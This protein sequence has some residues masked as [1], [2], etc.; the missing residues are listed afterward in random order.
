[1]PKG[2]VGR[3]RRAVTR[4]NRRTMAVAVSPLVAAGGLTLAAGAPAQAASGATWDRL[5]ACESGGNWSINTGNGYYGGLQFS[6][7]T[8][9]AYGGERYADNAHQAS[10]SEQIAIAEKTLAGQ[11]WG[12]WPACSRKLGLGASDKGGS[13]EAPPARE[14]RPEQRS[15]ADP[16]SAER[17]AP[18]SSRSQ[19]RSGERRDR[20]SAESSRSSGSYTVRAGDTLAR[21]ASAQGV[22]GGW[23]ALWEANSGTVSN[24]N[25]I[26]VGQASSVKIYDRSFVL[27]QVIS[28]GAGVRKLASL[29]HGRIVAATDAGSVSLAVLRLPSS[30]AVIDGVVVPENGWP[31]SLPAVPPA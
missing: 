20:R 28:L 24:P 4:N 31:L 30:G 17:A 26:F 9:D 3:H 7:S 5:A 14:A 22:S 23:R 19:E 11:G 27:V 16:D 15:D 13:A 18:R 12:A 8:W 2:Y 6:P 10:R 1:M 25:L 29:G 21:I